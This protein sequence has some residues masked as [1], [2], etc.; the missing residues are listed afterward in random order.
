MEAVYTAA[1]DGLGIQNSSQETE[2]SWG[3]AAILGYF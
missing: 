3:H 1:T 2:Q